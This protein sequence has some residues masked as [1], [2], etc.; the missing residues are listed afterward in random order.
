MAG[1]RRLGKM[2]N[3]RVRDN[4]PMLQTFGQRPQ[5]RP[6]H[7]GDFGNLAN[8]RG[9]RVGGRFGTFE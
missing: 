8:R 1:D 4:D 3:L 9:N 7:H 2:R 6:E 5:A